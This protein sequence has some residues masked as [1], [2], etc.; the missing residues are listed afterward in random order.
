MLPA[1]R[2]PRPGTRE[3]CDRGGGDSL[4]PGNEGLRCPLGLAGH[5]QSPGS[6][7]SQLS[8]MV[9]H[10]D[11]G[12]PQKHQLLQ[13]CFPA[14]AGPLGLY[15]CDPSLPEW[16]GCLPG[17]AGVPQPAPS[18]KSG[19]SPRSGA[20]DT[21]SGWVWV[22]SSR[23]HPAPCTEEVR[24]Q[25]QLCNPLGWQRLGW[26][27]LGLGISGVFVL[28][29][30]LGCVSQSRSL[31]S[32]PDTVLWCPTATLGRGAWTCMTPPHSAAGSGCSVTPLCP[33]LS[34][35]W[36]F[37]RSWAELLH[38]FPNWGGGSAAPTARAQHWQERV[39][40]WLWQA[41]SRGSAAVC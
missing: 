6:C 13:L 3:W 41:A 4:Q 23:R 36:L 11:P 10:C 35:S 31:G 12:A 25:C 29:R 17:G 26:G 14:A 21:A 9:G 20:P 8:M 24:R 27:S 22:P 38:L 39:W 33:T 40:P 15:Q 28:Q 32:P 7:S 5:R 30:L 2:D 19:M 16:G 37:S 18:P 1:G 34:Y